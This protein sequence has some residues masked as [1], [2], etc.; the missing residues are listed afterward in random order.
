MDYLL[1]VIAAILIIL[2]L[3]G[4][5]LPILPGPPLSFAAILLG[6]FTRWG[7]LETNL[8]LWLGLAAAAVTVVDY[9][10]PIWAM[11][12]FGGSKRGVRGATIGLIVGI[13]FFPPLGIILGPFIGTLIGELTSRN[14]MHQSNAFKSAFGSFFGFL[15][16]TGLKFAVSGVITYYFITQ[17]FIC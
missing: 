3:L 4:C 7:H 8:L 16:G 17:V 6:H 2:G 14:T 10:L 12:K 13:F 11:K 5:I 15:L 9:I 1:I